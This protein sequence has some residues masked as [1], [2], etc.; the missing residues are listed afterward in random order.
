MMWEL[1]HQQAP[2]Q[3]ALLSENSISAPAAKFFG[4]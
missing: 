1:P 2:P 4:N 3:P